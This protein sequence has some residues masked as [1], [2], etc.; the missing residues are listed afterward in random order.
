M[1]VAL[2]RDSVV[3]NRILQT[4]TRFCVKE[5]ALLHSDSLL[6]KERIV[7]NK[8][9]CCV[10]KRRCCIARDSVTYNFNGRILS[11]ILKDFVV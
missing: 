4:K 6:H 11:H 9:V 3:I 5:E 7:L 8:D 1:A 2:R 10:K